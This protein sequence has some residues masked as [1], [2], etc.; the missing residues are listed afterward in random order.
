MRAHVE[1]AVLERF[2]HHIL[3]ANQNIVIRI[4]ALGI[5]QNL[6]GFPKRAGLVFANGIENVDLVEV[7][8][9]ID[10]RGRDERTLDIDNGFGCLGNIFANGLDITAVDGDIH[11]VVPVAQ[12]GVLNEHLHGLNPPCE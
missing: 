3:G 9:G 1:R 2:K 5:P 12:F 6:D 7:N 10:Q 8:M 4:V 11:E